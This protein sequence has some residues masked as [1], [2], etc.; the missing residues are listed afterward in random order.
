MAYFYSYPLRQ[1][2]KINDEL[3]MLQ[4]KLAIKYKKNNSLPVCAEVGSHTHA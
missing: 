3:L 2:V 4:L 1:N